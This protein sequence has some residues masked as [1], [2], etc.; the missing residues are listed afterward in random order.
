M[1]M[2]KKILTVGMVILFIGIISISAEASAT[3]QEP[4]IEGPGWQYFIIGRIKSYE[5]V[6]Y[7]GTE[8]LNCK[9]VR[10]K[11]IFWNVSEKFP[12]IPII[13]KIRSGSEF[14]IPYEGAKIYGPINLRGHYFIVAKG[15][16]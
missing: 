12:R 11:S 13:I 4:Q 3:E 7:N 14:N 15:I 9:A 1:K 16:L 6:E 2:K 5:I 10:A 8:Y